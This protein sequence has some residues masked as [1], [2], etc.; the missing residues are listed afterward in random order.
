MTM[1][2]TDS[3]DS[4]AG[5]VALVVGASRGVG[6]AYAL[7]LAQAGAQVAAVARR[8]LPLEG[9][10]TSLK[11]VVE[12]AQGFGASILA[13]GA[14]I[15]RKPEIERVVDEALAHFGRVDILVYN[16]TSSGYVDAMNI[17]DEHWDDVLTMNV[18]TPYHFIR[19]LAPQMIARRSGNIVLMTSKTS[20]PVP[21]DDPGHKNLLAY[22][23]SKAAL[24]RIGSFFAEE[25]KQHDIAVNMLSP[26]IVAELS[27]GKAPTVE[28]FA[29]PL[30]H[31]ARQTAQTMTG[32]WRNTTD[33]GV[34]W[35]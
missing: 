14:D 17:P 8:V 27:G 24:N 29:P 18:K 16:A 20:L 30:L 13:L 19:L 5:K 22:G 33:F 3:A 12:T 21:Y 26:G 9:K 4:L 6:R 28:Q 23:A 1:R 34:A 32:Q 31:L 11:E 25:L 15:S 10:K 2:S 7:G 35:P